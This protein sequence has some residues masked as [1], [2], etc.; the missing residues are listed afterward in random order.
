MEII[1]EDSGRGPGLG[2]EKQLTKVGGML[3]GYEKK[4]GWRHGF[5]TSSG[6]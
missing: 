2:G 5:G 1:T 6:W 4:S 3:S